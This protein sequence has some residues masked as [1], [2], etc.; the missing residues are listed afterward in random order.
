MGTPMVSQPP[1]DHAPPAR[2]RLDRERLERAFAVLAA[3][4]G[5][6]DLPAAVL[7]VAGADGPTQ[8]RAFGEEPGGRVGVHDRF[9]V[10]SVTKPIVAVAALQQVDAGRLTLAE[11]I[12]RLLPEFAPA[13]PE[14]GRPD[15][16]RVSLWHLLT[17]TAGLED[18]EW[19]GLGLE[20]PT[21]D[22]LLASIC[23]RPLWAVPGTS[24]RYCSD[25]FYLIGELVRRVAGAPT[26]A[27]ALRAGVLEPLGM[28]ATGFDRDRDG[29][30]SVGAHVAGFD[31]VTADRFA[32]WISSVEHPGGGLWTTA[33]DLVAF[34]R[35]VLERGTARGVRILSPAMVELMG[36]EHTAGIHEPGDPPRRPT[37]GLGW[38]KP[39]LDGRMP[40]SPATVDHRGS[41]GSRL[42]IDPDAG[43][44]IALLANRWG[45]EDRLSDAVVSAVYGA[46]ER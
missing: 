4:V 41:S 42:W 45:S 30:R 27:A 5:S 17:H 15:G 35:M 31:D 19:V 1:A 21:A 3:Q 16:S 29:H 37:Y 6:G 22:D 33:A 18:L 10:A 38:G 13:P 36:R 28:S 40:G 34:G 7:A 44:V 11:P 23:E 43:L 8:V 25:A 32:D 12:R 46:L 2:P 24:Y 39:G 14:P 20:P 9:L 26:F